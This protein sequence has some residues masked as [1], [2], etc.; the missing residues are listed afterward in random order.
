MKSALLFILILPFFVHANNPSLKQYYQLIHH[1]EMSI[2]KNDYGAAL[3][4]YRDA[5]KHHYLFSVDLHNAAVVA[6]KAKVTK[7]LL[8][9]CKGLFERGLE[10]SYLNS[11]EDSLVFAP[12]QKQI[13]SLS[14]QV[15]ML[16]S[17][18]RKYRDEILDM[19]RRDQQF[20]KSTQMR[21]QYADTIK[22]I[23]DA[24]AKRLLELIDQYGYPSDE[25][26]GIPLGGLGCVAHVIMMHQAFGSNPVYDFSDLVKQAV[27]QGKQDN[28]TGSVLY[29]ATSGVRNYNQ[30]SLIRGRYDSAVQ[31]Q[32]ADGSY[33]QETNT[34]YT[35]WG[36]ESI[37]MEDIQQCNQR[38]AEWY[39]D[40]IQD[41]FKKFMYNSE[42]KAFILGNAN[43]GL[44]IGFGNYKDFLHMKNNLQAVTGL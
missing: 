38:R 7:D 4:Y 31:I 24:N 40:T 41:A 32:R 12:Y 28:R 29:E 8:F 37:K 34:L 11:G 36:I 5:G 26:T 9:F 3:K 19:V 44:T 22:K 16:K 23:F 10:V 35:H 15:P 43:A 21:K 30:F 13:L 33:V 42:N 27:L 18:N 6:A 17:I 25:L 14:Q 39:M 1:A 2:V 20:L